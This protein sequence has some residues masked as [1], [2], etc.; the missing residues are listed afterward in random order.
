LG[1]GALTK[2]LDVEA[3]IK[4][5]DAEALNKVLDAEALSKVKAAENLSTCG[6][7]SYGEPRAEVRMGCSMSIRREG[8]S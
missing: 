3:P 5:L 8:R 2:V 4:V 7:Y 1:A 6:G